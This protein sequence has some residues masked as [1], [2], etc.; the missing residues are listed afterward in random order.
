MSDKEKLGELFGETVEQFM[1]DHPGVT[2][3]DM[4]TYLAMCMLTIIAKTGSHGAPAPTSMKTQYILEGYL[5]DAFQL[6]E[7]TSIKMQGG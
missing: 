1:R 5:M 7:R 6:C 4:A 2:H 3:I